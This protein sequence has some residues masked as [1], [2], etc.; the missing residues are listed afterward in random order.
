MFSYTSKPVEALKYRPLVAVCLTLLFLLA[1][2]YILQ[3][4]A[5]QETTF[6]FVE[7]LSIGDDEQASAEYLFAG[8]RHVTTD[9]EGNIYVVD[10]N[11]QEI[12][13]FSSSG[14]YLETLGSAG[15][16]P[17]EF[18]G[19][20]AIAIDQA[21]G[22]VI[23]AD[24]RQRRFTVF[25]G[26]ERLPNTIPYQVEPFFIRQL[27]PMQQ[28]M[29]VVGLGPDAEPTNLR[30][31]P[32]VHL[33]SSDLQTV[34]ESTAPTD[35]WWD[36]SEAFTLAQQRALRLTV[37]GTN[38][39]EVLLVPQYY[40]GTLYHYS[41][42]ADAW[43]MGELRGREIDGAP[44]T[45][46]DDID[47]PSTI[48]DPKALYSGVA[49]RFVVVVHRQSVGL[50]TR[51]D[52]SIVHFT[53]ENDDTDGG[54]LWVELFDAEGQLVRTGRVE[55]YAEGASALGTRVLWKD[56]TDRFYVVDGRGDFPVLRVVSLEG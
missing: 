44:I 8:P 20:S 51:T 2:G 3:P 43:E 17:G 14:T 34:R 1:P 39:D 23:V 55:G 33:L 41:K 52:D 49:G 31:T 40:D 45:V 21:S 53:Y 56:A 19:L 26:K 35:D 10:R 18:L 13:V 9:A 7:H 28:G 30:P 46:Y 32:I 50:F 4:A 16:G 27:H 42:R 11:D 15:Q 48:P 5:A 36:F 47:D 24:G 38:S 12:R 29:L 54:S 6:R 25:S 22:D 37:A